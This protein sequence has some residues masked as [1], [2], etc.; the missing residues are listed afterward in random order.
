MAGAIMLPALPGKQ[1][2]TPK[3]RYGGFFYTYEAVSD[4]LITP[5]RN[6]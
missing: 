1:R 6:N 5:Y 2:K 3:T 4:N